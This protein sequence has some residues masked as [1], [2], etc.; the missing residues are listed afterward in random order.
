MAEFQQRMRQEW[1]QHWFYLLFQIITLSWIVWWI[2]RNHLP[3]PG[4]AVAV[5]AVLAAL[6]SVHT[7]IQPH[8]KF[9][10]FLL[11]GALLVTEIR[12]I[13]KDREEAQKEQYLINQR[14]D[15]RLTALLGSERDNTKKLLDQEN[16][17]FS[18][19][20]KQDQVE[21]EGTIAALLTTHKQDAREFAGIVQQGNKM[22]QSQ[23]DISEQ[24]AGRLV[25][26]DTPTPANA[27]DAMANNPQTPLLPDTTTVLWGNN[28]AALTNK[29]TSSLIDV[30]DTSVV[31]IDRHGSNVYLSVDFRDKQ[32]QILIRL[33]KNGLVTRT[34]DLSVLHPDKSTFLIED[35]LGEEFFRITYL[36]PHAFQISGKIVFCGRPID[37]DKLPFSNDCT[38][39]PGKGVIKLLGDSKCPMQP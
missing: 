10:Y 37:I 22:I 20:L 13:K 18:A 31:A 7:N 4:V 1:K 17:N 6:M 9:I 16:V 11:I 14:A 30:G 21:F 8:H 24:F 2:W 27:C 36:N 34:V 19:N 28:N 26:G 5:I 12:A 29:A 23:R 32:N 15:D 39:Y 3:L 25:P 33:N 38:A 35:R